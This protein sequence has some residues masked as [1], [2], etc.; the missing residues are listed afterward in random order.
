MPDIEKK[1]DFPEKY[2]EIQVMPKNRYSRKNPEVVTLEY[3][4]TWLYVLQTWK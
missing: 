4:I 1:Q 3:Y 2:Q